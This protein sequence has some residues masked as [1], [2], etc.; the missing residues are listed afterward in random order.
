MDDMI[1]FG[2][3]KRKLHKMRQAIAD[4]LKKYLG[5]E[6]KGN[7]QV[8]PIK[9]RALDFM[10]FRF[11]RDKVILRKSIMLKA[12]RKARRIAKKDKVSW[13][14]AAQMVSY[15]GW[16]K[17]C[18]TYGCFEARIYPYVQKRN[19]RKKISHHSRKVA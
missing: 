16:F 5:L 18:D 1:I 6:L 10:G 8:F 3:N 14:D 11:F 12:S 13:Y 19:L 4:Y 2:S 9:S 17:S 15:C 7:Y